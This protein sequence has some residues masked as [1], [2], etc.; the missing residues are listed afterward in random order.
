MVF[1]SVSHPEDKLTLTEQSSRT[2]LDVRADGKT[3][4]SQTT[5]YSK[6]YRWVSDGIYAGPYEIRM[7]CVNYELSAPIRR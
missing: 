2:I 3:R 6:V 5:T 4:W 1:T 7:D